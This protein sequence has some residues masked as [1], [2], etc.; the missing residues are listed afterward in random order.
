MT[1]STADHD[2][3]FLMTGLAFLA[4]K[5]RVID[6]QLRL[7]GSGG[8]KLRR[9]L[10]VD[11]ISHGTAQ[12]LAGGQCSERLAQCI[13][14]PGHE[15]ISGLA[16]LD[17][18]GDT[19]DIGTDGCQFRPGAF[20]NGIGESLG[21]TGQ[22]VD[23]QCTV[24]LGHVIHPSGEKYLIPDPQ[25]G[26]QS[27]Q[28]LQLCAVTGDHQFEIRA[29]SAGLRNRTDQRGNVLDGIQTCGDAGNDIVFPEGTADALK[30]GAAVRPGNGNGKVDAVIYGEHVVGPE[31]PL[32]EG[33][34]HL[35]GHADQI[36]HLTDCPGIELSVSESGTG[37]AHIIQPVIAVDGTDHRQIEMAFQDRGHEIGTGAV[38]M[39]QIVGTLFDPMFDF[40]HAD[41]KTV[42]QYG[43][44]D[45]HGDGF[46]GKGSL[47]E[48]DQICRDL[49][50]ETC[51]QGKYMSFGASGVSAGNKMND[52][53]NDP[54]LV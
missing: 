23:V 32:D 33:A 9:C 6:L 46:P 36:I 22:R 40:I 15:Q 42:F 11:G 14:I 13:R 28:R 39:D 17:E 41:G 51:Q 35:I 20:G 53:Q 12:I 34:L 48:T 24:K 8:G 52:V 3:V 19:A 30:I 26:G 1:V 21:E 45:T 4:A 38:T 2:A 31:P 25:C 47:H 29:G 50:I 10:L 16:V 54:P 5:H 37:T 7:T 18:L 44:R 43:Y 49:L 27:L